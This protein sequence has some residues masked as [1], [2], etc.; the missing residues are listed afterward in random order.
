M[1]SFKKLALE[2]HFEKIIEE[3]NYFNLVPKNID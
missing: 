1:R 3:E 2:L